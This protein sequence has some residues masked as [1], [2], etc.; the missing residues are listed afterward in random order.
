MT[1]K[2]KLDKI[3][4]YIKKNYKPEVGEKTSLWSH[5]NSD[6]VFSDGWDQGE[7]YAL[8]EIGKMIGMEL[9]DPH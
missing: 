7:C 1:D 3:E 4:A 5:G 6:D 8:W 2:E 9:P